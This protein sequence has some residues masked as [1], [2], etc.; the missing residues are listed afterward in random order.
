MLTEQSILY[1]N[2][3]SPT[4]NEDLLSEQTSK[5]LSNNCEVVEQKPKNGR[6]LLNIPNT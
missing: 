2:T 1:G 4:P 3:S 6:T 5:T